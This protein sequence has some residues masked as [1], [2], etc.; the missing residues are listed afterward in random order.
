ARNVVLAGR[1]QHIRAAEEVEAIGRQP[2]LQPVSVFNIA[3]FFSRASAVVDRDAKLSPPDCKRLKAHYADR[4][5]DFLN[6]SVA[7]G[8]RVPAAMKNDRDLEPLRGRADFQKLIADLEAKQK[9]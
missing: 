8:F 6:Q 1:G 9:E 4:A 5:M 2:D 7:K 3:C